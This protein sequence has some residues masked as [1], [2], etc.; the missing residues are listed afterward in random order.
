MKIRTR[1]YY[2]VSPKDVLDVEIRLVYIPVFLPYNA[3]CLNLTSLN[4]KEA[5]G[6]IQL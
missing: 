5:V 3:T 4:V 1:L 2:L 6:C